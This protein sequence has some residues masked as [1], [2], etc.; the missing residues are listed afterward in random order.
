[1]TIYTKK[2]QNIAKKIGTNTGISNWKDWKWQLKHSIHDIDTFERLLGI[3][4]SEGDKEQ[5]GK[6]IEKFPLS[7]T[8]Y[9]LSLIE[10]NNYADD[11]VFRQSFPSPCELEVNLC[12]H[13]DPLDEE[14][15]S[16]A[17]GITHRY[18][19]RVL[20]HISN[21]CS[22]YCR[23]CTRKRKVGD[24]DSIPSREEITMGLEYIR[25]TPV[26]RDVLLSG[27]DPL[28]LSDEYLDWI[29]G[30]LRNI[31]HVQVIR[32]GS[33]MPVVLPYRITDTLLG[34]LKKL[35]PVWLNT[36]FPLDLPPLGQQRG[37]LAAEM[38]LGDALGHRPD[39]DPT[40]IGR[41]E[42]SHHFPEL[43]ALF[44]ALDLPAHADP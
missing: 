43:G 20:F 26:V 34:V 11:P 2:Q 17:P 5:I 23:H 37:N 33:R 38:I 10:R 44:P 40:G 9:Y 24:S 15:D 27:G 35:S 28:M 19:D 30:E 21:I 39:D 4:F 6:T 31:P 1:M 3:T 29:L 22:M 13:A 32:I 16:P 18:P 12:D 7:I 41:E 8:P 25:N 36:L 14:A 42:A